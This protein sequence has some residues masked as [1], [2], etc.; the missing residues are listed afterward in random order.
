M[1]E[2]GKP[3]DEAESAMRANGRIPE[4]A[5]LETLPDAVLREIVSQNQG[6]F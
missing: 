3:V 5:I 4:R 1:D 6:P 2:H